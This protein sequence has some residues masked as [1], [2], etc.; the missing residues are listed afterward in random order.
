[1][2]MAKNDDQE[3]NKSQGMQDDFGEQS[4][5]G[6]NSETGSDEYNSEVY[7]EIPRNKKP[8]DQDETNLSSEEDMEELDEV[9]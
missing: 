1:M 6:Q 8:G 3:M 9:A 2:Y 7:Q 5:V 4:E